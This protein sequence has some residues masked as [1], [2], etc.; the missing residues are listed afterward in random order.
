MNKSSG[1][2]L[3]IITHLPSTLLILS[4]DFKIVH[5]SHSY[6]QATGAERHQIV[7]KNV[8]EAFPDNPNDAKADG[9]K[10]LR[11]SLMKV[12]RT[13]TSQRMPVQKYDV[14]LPNGS[15]REKYWNVINVPVIG[16]DKEIEHLIH[17]VTDVTEQIKTEAALELAVGAAEL[18]TW[19]ID[20]IKN[21]FRHRNL[22]HDQIYGYKELQPTWSH[23]IAKK[24]ILQADLGEYDRA[25][26]E[27]LRTG[28][29][30]FEVR[31]KWEDGS[32]H[33]VEVKGRVYFDS[34]GKPSTAAGVNIDVTEQ[35]L[36][37]IAF[38]EAKEK[39]E[40][41]AKAKD[42]FLSTM[43]HEIRTPLN[44]VIGISNL[45]LEDELSKNQRSNLNALHFAADNL[46]H[47]VNNVLD[48]SKIQAGKIEVNPKIFDL[49]N[50]ITDIITT[51]KPKAEEKNLE[52]LAKFGKKIPLK[53]SSDP[54]LLTQI[55]HNLIGNALKF[56][57]KG[58]I[59]VVVECVKEKEDFQWI[60]FSVEDTGKGISSDKLDYIFEEFAQQRSASEVNFEGT[61]LGLPITKSLVQML[62]GNI[63]VSSIPGKGSKFSFD[64]PT[65]KDSHNTEK[66][67]EIEKQELIKDLSEKQ[68][69]LVEDVEINRNI[70]VQYLKKWWNL[71]PDE[72]E[73]G[74]Q[75]LKKAGKH[76]YDLIL[77]DLRMPLMDGYEA[78]QNIRRLNN[79][80]EI[81]ILAFT[82]DTSNYLED[83]EI[84][85]ET[86][87]KPFDPGDLRS[88]IRKYLVKAG[89]A[90][91][92]VEVDDKKEEEKDLFD[93]ARFEQM[94]AG[95]AKILEK[96]IG[97]SI[98]AFQQY[99]DDFK[100]VKD[101][102]ALADLIHRNT[103][104]VHYVNAKGL[105]EKIRE[106]EN[107]L[108]NCENEKKLQSK[109]REILADFDEILKGLKKICS[110]STT[111]KF[112]M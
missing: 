2:F 80:R 100:I 37:E 91:E 8:F 27:A 56:T 42:E 89:N 79:Y 38:Q 98:K 19:E 31:T 103:M 81:P 84:F 34:K 78:T 66:A 88:K 96:F 33:W 108:R 25:F 102:A 76:Q 23:A 75:A 28:S 99:R 51:H 44:A 106:F 90:K 57:N 6:L 11:A 92:F 46:L 47:L 10:N 35:R 97:V 112:D 50:L 7:G 24:N 29:I 110:R 9:V 16:E 82:A 58:S 105:Q 61:G 48:F 18:G 53:I 71:K 87:F 30:D 104:N 60:R 43:S 86:I 14:P 54:F 52:L 95:E 68:I 73:N 77:M 74:E 13:R 22:R 111:E 21:S 32:I 70:I 83:S 67:Q 4:P 107:S 109:K 40:L 39:A 55:L 45:L 5:A 94:A 93:I 69:L 17:S 59:S 3:N 12:L 85:D 49:S 20:L 41:A 65:A 36:T 62:G 63:E 15:F 64:L 1:E 26:S 101:E 72:A